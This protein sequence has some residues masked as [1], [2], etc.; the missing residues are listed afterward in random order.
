MKAAQITGYGGQEVMQ[1]VDGVERPALGEGQVLVEVYAAAVN[2]FDWKVREGQFKP[3]KLPAVLGS[4]L[5]GVVAELGPGVQG[6]EVGQAVFGAANGLSGQGSFAEFAPANASASALKPESIDFVEAASL[7]IVGVSA[8]QV[9]VEHMKL[10]GGQK[11]LIHGGAGGI[12]SIAIQLAKHFGAYIATTISAEDSDYVQ[13][14]GADEV[15]DYRSQDFS[16]L[17]EGYDAVFDT[18]GGETTTQSYIVLKPGGILVSMVSPPDEK[19]MEQYGVRYVYQS[20][21]S[22]TELLT[23]VAKLVDQGVLKPNIDKTFPLEQAAEALEYL[24]TQHPHGKVVIK[25]K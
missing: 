12:G 5:A 21:K 16:Q 20:T 13:A 14:L 15:I 24:K 1:T 3:D 6:L 19:L 22:T 18:V 25:I 11:I 10:Q 8:Y 4:D 7:P 17:L 2:P 9:I 23:K